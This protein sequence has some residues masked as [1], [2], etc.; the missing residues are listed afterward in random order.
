MNDK[1][2]VTN[3]SALK[4]KYGSAFG[5][6]KKAIGRLIAADKQRGI[7]TRLVALDDAAAMKKLKAPA[8]KNAADPKQNKRAIDGVFKALAPEYVMLLGSTDIIPHQDMKNPVFDGI[9]DADKFAYGDLPY[10]CETPYSQNAADFIGP[11]RVVGRLPDV[12]GANDPAYLV[13]LLE[14]AANAKSLAR[15]D[16]TG[17]LGISAKVWE[18]STRLSLEKLFGSGKDVRLSPKEG[19][20]WKAEA[21]AKRTHFVNCHGAPADSNFYGQSGSNFPTAHSAELLAGKISEGAVAAVECCYGAELYDPSLIDSNQ[22]GI[23]NTY[24]A[25]KAYGYLGSTTIAYGPAEGNG[26]ADLICR[27]FLQRVLSGASTGRAALEARQE[28]AT[29]AT[30]LDPVDLKTMAQF[31]LLG[32]P[33]IHPVAAETPHRVIA[34]TR[35][36]KAISPL[37]FNSAVDRASRRQQLANRG[38]WIAQHQPVARR[39]GSAEAT[40]KATKAHPKAARGATEKA[41]PADR[42]TIKKLITDA[43][44]ESTTT[45]SYEVAPKAPSMPKALRT[46]VAAKSLPSVRIHVVLGR[47]AK[48]ERATREAAPEGV[49]RAI[50]IIAR[51]INGK[52]ISYREMLMK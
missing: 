30:E 50:A 23:C 27:F 2:I 25:N 35:D 45:Q 7:N 12:T 36:G 22:S 39:V 15:S 49:V 14:T 40:K 29:H 46:L 38:L 13:E 24:L 1:V 11:T 52:I 37:A 20:K 33:S 17:F 8:V 48:G 34:P 44:L 18:K 51:E 6:V 32:D 42:N 47:R 19:P 10:A 5:A 28:F 43:D 16:Y 3:L 41:A 31:N 9:N 26:A 4:K 21:L